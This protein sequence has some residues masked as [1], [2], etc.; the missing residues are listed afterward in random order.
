[1]LSATAVRR[2]TS[3]WV[4][5]V[6]AVDLNYELLL[7]FNVDTT[8]NDA[9]AAATSAAYVHQKTIVINATCYCY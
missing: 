6:V 2:D 9:D 5:L 7:N 1:M 8:T 3:S 4:V